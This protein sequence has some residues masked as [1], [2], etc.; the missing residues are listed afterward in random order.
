MRE[1]EGEREGGKMRVNL[2]ISEFFYTLSM[3]LIIIGTV[4]IIYEQI[5]VDILIELKI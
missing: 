1:R 3:F 4:I 2:F 5:Q